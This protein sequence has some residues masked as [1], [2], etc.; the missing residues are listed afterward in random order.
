MKQKIIKKYLSV[1]LSPK[2]GSPVGF[3]RDIKYRYLYYL[4][5]YGRQKSVDWNKVDRIV[6]VCKGN[7]CRSAFAEIVACSMNINA[8]SCGL[9]T[10]EGAQANSV[11]MSVAASMGFDLSK[12]R[13]R[14]IEALHVTKSDLLVAME[15]WQLLRLMSIYGDKYQ[16]TLIGLWGMPVKP[17]I[18]DPYGC[19]DEYFYSCFRYIFKTLKSISPI[20]K[21]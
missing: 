13:T 2:Y 21:T 15:P 19:S 6:F 5:I 4:G 8:V 14:M 10:S 17:Y 11:A 7:I 16:Y 1:A 18:H 9:D 20:V 12:H 3:L